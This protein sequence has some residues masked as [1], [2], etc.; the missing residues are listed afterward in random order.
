MYLTASYIKTICRQITLRSIPILC[1]L[2]L[3]VMKG[4][5]IS[6]QVVWIMQEHSTQATNI[7]ARLITGVTGGKA[8]TGI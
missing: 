3:L 2:L 5:Y 7:S 1:L 4:K 8:L 6:M